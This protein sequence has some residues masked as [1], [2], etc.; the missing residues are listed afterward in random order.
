V[1]EKLGQDKEVRQA[2]NY[3]HL[4]FLYAKDNQPDAAITAFA[5]F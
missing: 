3:F 2:H 4:G 5:K 1:S